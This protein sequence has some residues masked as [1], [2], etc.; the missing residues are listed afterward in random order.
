MRSR[1]SSRD[2]VLSAALAAA[3]YY[4]AC[5]PYA[6][7]P[8]AARRPDSP[9]LATRAPSRE[10]RVAQEWRD[11]LNAGRAEPPERAPSSRAA[12]DFARGLTA[13]AL[14]ITSGDAHRASSP[15][16][17]S[18]PARPLP[19]EPG[20]AVRAAGP[21]ESAGDARG[22]R[23]RARSAADAKERAGPGGKESCDASTNADAR[24]ETRRGLASWRPARI[25]ARRAPQ[26]EDEDSPD[27]AVDLRRGRR[28]ASSLFE[29][30]PRPA[31]E[32]RRSA[33]R[34]PRFRPPRLS[35]LLGGIALRPPPASLR[36]PV[37][38][39]GLAAKRPASDAMG[40]IV[41]P[42]GREL[43]AIEAVAPEKTAS[44]RRRNA[45]WDGETWHER[46]AHGLARD[47]GWLWLQKDGA[48][49]W[50]LVDRTPLVRHQNIWWLRRSGVWLVLHEGEPWAWRHFQDWGAD[51][52]FHPATG[53][54]IVYSPDLSRAAVIAPGEGAVIYDARSG[55][56]IGRIPES[57]M[58]ARR[59]PKAPKSLSL[60]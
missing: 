38:L 59:R 35:Q 31:R 36:P 44:D 16:E 8:L 56:E 45:H 23:P 49:W 41:P 7:S 29:P 1:I 12:S 52:L 51:G 28:R 42:P 30:A 13:S 5:P 22:G 33:L 18:A 15:R 58:P 37:A 14:G 17:A 50:G 47:G 57:A 3:A 60:P 19:R 34:A 25:A 4:A 26:P 46:R 10:A 54:E 39:A 27:G 40:R 32:A 6:V 43:R 20:P 48:R 24:E 11:A 55:A 9:R 2:V 21:G 53:T